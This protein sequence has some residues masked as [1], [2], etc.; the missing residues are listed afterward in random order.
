MMGAFATYVYLDNPKKELES[1]EIFKEYKLLSSTQ[2]IYQ[3]CGKAKDKIQHTP[4]EKE[5]LYCYKYNTTSPIPVKDD[6][7][8]EKN[9]S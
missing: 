3:N 7:L 6:S 5:F 8:H 9:S 4:T 2:N 1:D